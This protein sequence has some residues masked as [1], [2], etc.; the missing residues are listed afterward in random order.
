MS[1][2]QTLPI[3]FINKDVFT[4]MV[5]RKQITTSCQ[6]IKRNSVIFD[7]DG[8]VLLC[9]HLNYCMGKYLK[10]FVDAH[11][12]FEFWNSRKIVDV[13]K[14]ITTMPSHKCLNCKDKHICGGG[15]C[16]QWFASDFES[17][18][19]YYSTKKQKA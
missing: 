13:Y 1:L 6:L 12:F 17:Y 19:K 10:D 14:K 11:S 8:G 7:T 2:H 15:C 5:D 18:N 3:C 16:I 9:N 4:K